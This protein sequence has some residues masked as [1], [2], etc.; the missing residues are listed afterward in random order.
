MFARPT[1]LALVAAFALTACHGNAP[2]SRAQME[3]S[4]QEMEAQ[5][6]A[7]AE[8]GA[9]HLSLAPMVGTWN[10]TSQMWS[11]PGGEAIPGH[12]TMTTTWTLG[13]RFLEERF[14]GEMMGQAFEGRGFL[15]YD[16]FEERYQGFWIDTMGTQMMPVS[17]GKISK[18]GK[19][20]SL[21]REVTD[22]TTGGTARMRD[23]TTIVSPNEIRFQM[24]WQAEG[25]DEFLMMDMTMKRSS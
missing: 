4:L 22:P 18:D 20:F 24:Y 21:E 8:P 7:L 16:N 14:Q 17:S 11:S 13:G 10:T 5:M 25:E 6:A 3:T 2:K 19:V 15:G 9:A 23:V 1:A 12:G